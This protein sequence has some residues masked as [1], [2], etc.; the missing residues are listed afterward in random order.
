MEWKTNIDLYIHK[1]KN[2]AE[3]QKISNRQRNPNWKKEVPHTTYSD[4]VSMHCDIQPFIT[5][6]HT[7]V[8]GSKE[9]IFVLAPGATDFNNLVCIVQGG[10]E[11]HGQWVACLVKDGK[12]RV[13]AR[14]KP[15]LPRACPCWLTEMGLTYLLSPSNNAIKLCMS[16]D[17]ST[18]DE[19]VPQ[20]PVTSMVL[21]LW[22]IL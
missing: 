7:W 15:C 16:M 4:L 14:D 21:H 20:E 3:P 1:E 22:I 17:K 12:K 5:L 9:E 2:D 13:R 19:N 10:T 11:H 18:A 6:T 8:I